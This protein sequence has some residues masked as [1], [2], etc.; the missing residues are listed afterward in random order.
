MLFLEKFTLQKQTLV[1][2]LHLQYFLL[3]GSLHFVDNRLPLFAASVLLPVECVEKDTDIGFSK[4][5]ITWGKYV[6]VSVSLQNNNKK[7][8]PVKMILTSL[9]QGPLQTQ[10]CLGILPL[11]LN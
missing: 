9:S 8:I 6:N 1:P 3:K 4:F 2:R 11:V 7:T 10:I 5:T